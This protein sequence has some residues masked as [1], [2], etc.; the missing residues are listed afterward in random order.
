MIKDL[1]L[2]IIFLFSLLLISHQSLIVNH[3]YSAEATPSSIQAKLDELKKEIASKAASLKNNVNKKIQNKAYL[4]VI[5]ENNTSSIKIV[6][7]KGD[8]TI[9]INEY[10]LFQDTGKGAKKNLTIKDIAKDNTVVV[11]GDVDDRGVMTAK[12]VIRIPKREKVEPKFL[13]G[14]IQQV[15]NG[16][17]KILNKDNKALNIPTTG[18]TLFKLGQEES[19]LADA[20]VKKF[21]VAHMTGKEGA[22]TAKYIYYIPSVGFIKPEKRVAS[23]SA[24]T[25]PSPK[26][27]VKK[28]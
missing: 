25:S 4:G 24:S 28:N 5:I 26:P 27:T 2:K 3:A 17:I 22:E 10:T 12:K 11:L 13:W 14:Q 21:L 16:T 23:P 19:S 7:I 15:S 6:S 1:R 8:R 9:N 18:N 20:K